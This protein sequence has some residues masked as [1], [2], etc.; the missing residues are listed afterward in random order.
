M[1]PSN[2][3]SRYSLKLRFLAAR[4][5]CVK[6]ALNLTVTINNNPLVSC[7]PEGKKNPNQKAPWCQQFKKVACRPPG[8]AL[9]WKAWCASKHH[10]AQVLLWMALARHC[11]KSHALQCSLFTSNKKKRWNCWKM[12]PFALWLAN[13]SFQTSLELGNESEGYYLLMCSAVSAVF[14][15]LVVAGS[16]TFFKIKAWKMST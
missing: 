7:S 8:H 15:I 1:V 13:F 16:V 12:K 10:K 6:I 11:H 5:F 9:C 3:H 2:S 4:Q 14:I